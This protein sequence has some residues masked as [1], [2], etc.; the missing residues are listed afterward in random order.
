MDVFALAGYLQPP[1]K[2]DNTA[3]TKSKS[4]LMDDQKLKMMSVQ[5]FKDL[6]KDVLHN[7]DFYPDGVNNNMQEI[8]YTISYM[9][10]YCWNLYHML[11]HIVYSIFLDMI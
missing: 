6:I 2:Q 11:Y 9:I 7:K 8:L 5:G 1:W 3:F 4:I 10:S